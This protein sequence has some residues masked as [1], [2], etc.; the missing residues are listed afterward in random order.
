MDIPHHLGL[1]T[2]LAALFYPSFGWD[3]LLIFVGGV[4]I[5]IDHYAWYVYRYKDLNPVRCYR[6]FSFDAAKNK[7]RE[8]D[9]I[10]LV[11]H[12]IECAVALVTVS[13]FSTSALLILIGYAGHMLLDLMWLTREAKRLIIDYSVLHWLW[14]NKIKMVK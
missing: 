4:M 9:G 14:V 12:C 8:F 13:I 1:S 5:D 2:I 3:V 10:P 11:F 7:Y 6:K